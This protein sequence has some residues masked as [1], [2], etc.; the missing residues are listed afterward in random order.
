[1]KL[2]ELKIENFRSFKNEQIFFDDYTCLV[3][4]NGCGKSTVLMALNVFFRN[5]VTNGNIISLSKD[6]FHHGNISDPIKITLTFVGLSEEAKKDFK[7]Y[8]RQDKL[9]ISAKA[10]WDVASQ[11]A[12]VIQYGSRLVMAD[13]KA[14]FAKDKAGEKAP[15]LKEFYKNLREKYKDLPVANTKPEMEEALKDY[16]EK[17]PEL[18]EL[19]ESGDQFYGF[20]KGADRLPKYVQWVYIPAIKDPS[21]EQEES[22]KTALGQLLDRTVRTKVNF[23]D[24][25]DKNNFR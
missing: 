15:A 18:C 13:F 19:G 23:K 14:Y 21:A 22:K 6:D 4:A 12:P 5:S 16:E 7:E 3:G 20:T 11:S 17:H 25:M 9:I 1:M 8:F 2:K 24:H 10:I